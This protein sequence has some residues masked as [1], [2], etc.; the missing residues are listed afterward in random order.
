MDPE[1]ELVQKME[2][3]VNYQRKISNISNCSNSEPRI[4]ISSSTDRTISDNYVNS[5]SSGS[6]SKIPKDFFTFS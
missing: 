6:V 3:K 2:A 4:D 5:L 1:S